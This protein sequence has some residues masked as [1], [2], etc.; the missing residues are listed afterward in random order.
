MAL[1]NYNSAGQI[2]LDVPFTGETTAQQIVEAYNVDLTDKVIVITGGYV[3]LGLEA[4]RALVKTNATIVLGARRLETAQENVKD[5]IAAGAKIE[6]EPLDLY[7]RESIEQFAQ[8]FLASNR[9][10]DILINNAGI[11]SGQGNLVHDAAGNERLLTTNHLGHFVLTALLF[12]ALKRAAAPRVVNVS[13]LAARMANVPQLLEDPNFTTHDYE[14]QLSY[15]QSKAAQV[16]FTVELDAR[17]REAGIPLRV[18]ALHPGIVL[19]TEISRD[20]PPEA[21]QKLNDLLQFQDANGNINFDANGKGIKTIPQG[22]SSI[23]FAAISPKLLEVTSGVFIDS[24]NIPGVL[25]PDVH[26]L[27]ITNHGVQNELTLP[28]NTTKLWALT[29]KLTGV[30]FKVE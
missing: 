26:F 20:T 12:P 29:E 6:I 15:A 1:N 7:V 18:Y 5:L 2:P 25:G 27:D 8:K 11:T 23:V 10:L 4:T 9:P 16:L 19:Q 30:T 22:A 28:E 14:G 24:N 21:L 17:A 3:G 13:S